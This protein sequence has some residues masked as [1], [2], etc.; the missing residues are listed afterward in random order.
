MKRLSTAI[1][2]NI[3]PKLAGMLLAEQCG[4]KRKE[5]A[6]LLASTHLDWNLDRVAHALK[7]QFEKRNVDGKDKD[8]EDKPNTRGRSFRRGGGFK[9]RG[10]PKKIY[11]LDVNDDKKDRT[12]GEDHED[13]EDDSDDDS[14]EEASSEEDSNQDMDPKT[15]EVFANFTDAQRAWRNHKKGRG[16]QGNNA[17]KSSASKDAYEG[18]FNNGRCA[19]CGRGD[20]WKD[21]CPF[22]PRSEEQR[23]KD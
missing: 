6:V 21:E 19:I 17:S 7:A 9:R 3:P 22:P 20:H 11:N 13:D 18:S 16:W 14:D 23:Q 2:G 4:L 8:K 15:A 10:T 12:Q 1:E 5:I